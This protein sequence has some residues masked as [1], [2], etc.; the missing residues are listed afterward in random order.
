MK[1]AKFP[2]A[3]LKSYREFT[4]NRGK[5]LEFLKINPLTSEFEW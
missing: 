4:A 5:K 2:Q 1:L 3:Y